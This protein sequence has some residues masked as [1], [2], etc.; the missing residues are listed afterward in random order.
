[1][2]LD[3]RRR[4]FNDRARARGCR[5]ALLF[6]KALEDVWSKTR[7]QRCWVHKTANGLN[8]LP[9]N[10]RAKAKRIGGD[11]EAVECLTKDRDALLAFYDFPAEHWKHLR[12]SNP[13]ES[14]FATVHHRT[15]RSKGCLSNKRNIG[16]A[17]T[18]KTNCQRSLSG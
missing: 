4:R 18:G 17:S 11:L 12:T 15:V 5:G 3:L 1:M 13:V 2:L 16:V 7:G 9:K 6:W 8:K 14:T 10:Q